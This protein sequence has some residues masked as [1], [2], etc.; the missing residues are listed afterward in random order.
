MLQLPTNSHNHT[1]VGFVDEGCLFSLLQS[2]EWVA[3]A[4]FSKKIERGV[5]KLSKTFR[6]IQIRWKLAYQR[7]NEIMNIFGGSLCGT[8]IATVPIWSATNRKDHF[9]DT[10]IWFSNRSRCVHNPRYPVFYSVPN[11][12]GDILRTPRPVFFPEKNRI[13]LVW[14]PLL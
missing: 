1:D 14:D 11:S 9:F 8:K 5:S 12:L 6:I 3:T 2:P 7:P 10:K 4:R 13:P